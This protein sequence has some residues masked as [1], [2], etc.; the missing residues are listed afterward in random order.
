MFSVPNTTLPIFGNPPHRFSY[1]QDLVNTDATPGAH[2]APD[3]AG[4]IADNLV[5]QMKNEVAGV[6]GT[7]GSET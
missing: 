4:V 7:L 6:G 1:M 3:P 5:L 2:H